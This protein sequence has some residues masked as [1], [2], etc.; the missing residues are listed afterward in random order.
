MLQEQGP[1]SQGN[2][3][4]CDGAETMALTPQ[5]PAPGAD[6]G[7]MGPGPLDRRREARYKATHAEI[8]WR[9]GRTVPG[10]RW[11]HRKAQVGQLVDVSARGAAVLAPTGDDLRP[12]S[13]VTIELDGV[14]GTVTVRRVSSVGDQASS[15]YGIEF[16][17]AP[18]PLTTLIHEKFLAGLDPNPRP[19]RVEPGSP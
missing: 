13:R 15:L 1:R 18:S 17:E 3:A 4:S 16:E 5:T 14:I 11:W 2:D 8:R 6:S 9:V 7:G 10:L 12:G 19:P